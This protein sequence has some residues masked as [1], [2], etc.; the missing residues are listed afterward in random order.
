MKKTNKAFTLIELLVVV[1]IIGIL[2]AIAV[3]QY[4]KAVRKSHFSKAKDLVNNVAMAQEVYYLAN[5]HY[6]SSFDE[7]DIVLPS[8]YLSN[9]TAST[10]IYDWGHISTSS[11]GQSMAYVYAVSQNIQYQVTPPHSPAISNEGV[12]YAGKKICVAITTDSNSKDAKFCQNDTG[13]KD[14]D[15]VSYYLMYFYD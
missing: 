13:K 5:G 14:A 8:D 9:S 3:P 7:L 12:R 2:A 1:L 4:Q 6:S 10:K 15:I 11:S